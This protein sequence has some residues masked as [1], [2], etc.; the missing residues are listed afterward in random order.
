MDSDKCTSVQ[1]KEFFFFAQKA[2]ESTSTLN[3]VCP[4]GIK[5]SFFVA[6][7]R[8]LGKCFDILLS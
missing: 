1:I 2:D 4:R 5:V 3:A 8:Y 7:S 6:P